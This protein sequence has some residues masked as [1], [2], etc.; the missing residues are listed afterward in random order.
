MTASPVVATPSNPGAPMWST[1]RPADV[2]ERDTR[3]QK[4]IYWVVSAP[5]LAE[6]VAGIQWDF[7]RNPTVVQVLGTLQFPDYFADVLGSAKCLALAALLVP[8]FPRLKEW[9]YAGLT[10][11][12]FGASVCH[13][14]VGD[15]T[16][17]VLTPFVLGVLG[18]AS[19]ALRPPSRRDPRPLPSVWRRWRHARTTGARVS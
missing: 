2:A 8:G 9:A 16:G 3:R 1:E 5:V 7:A 11:V 4:V 15:S 6:T 19:W 12:Y 13:V 14:L 10:F 17:A 18:L